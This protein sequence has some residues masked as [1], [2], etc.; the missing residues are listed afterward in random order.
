MSIKVKCPGCTKVLT[1]PDAARGK[2]VKC[3]SCE[4]RVPVPKGEGEAAAKTAK[5]KKPAGP[6]EEEIA[7]ATLDLRKMED[8]KARLCPKCGYDMTYLGDEDEEITECPQ[9]GWDIA[10]GGLGE[11]ARK[12]ALKGPDPDQ[13][14]H[15]LWKNAWKFVFDNYFLA[16]RTFAYTMAASLIMF[17]S[18][19]MYLWISP[20]PP[21]VF[22]GF[23][24]FV[25][26]MVIPGWLWYL[27]TEVIKLTLE[28]KDR[29]KRLNFDFFLASALGV[30]FVVWNIVVAGP[31]LLIP[32]LIGWSLYQFAGL[33][34][35]IPIAILAVCY[36]PVFVLWPVSLTHMTMPIE[37]PGWMFW[38]VVPI[39]FR[40]SKALFT[41][42][43]LFIA[44]NLPIFLIGGGALAFSGPALVEYVEIMEHNAQINRAQA[45]W[46]YYA[47]SKKK[48]KDL[49]DPKELGELGTVEF[50]HELAITIGM[51]AWLICGL[52]G[53]FTSLFSMRTNGY[54]AYYFRDRLD[55]LVLPKERKYVAKLPREAVERKPQSTQEM[56]A[57]AGITMV[58]CVII[59]VLFRVLFAAAG[60]FN[61]EIPM[62]LLNGFDMGLGL[63]IFVGFSIITKAAWEES[64]LWGICTQWFNVAIGVVAVASFISFAFGTRLPLPFLV[65]VGVIGMMGVASI[66]AAFVFVIQFWE[67][68]GVGC[69]TAI[70]SLMGKIVL[71]P[72][73]LLAFSVNLITLPKGF[74]DNKEE[75]QKSGPPVAPG[76]AMPGGAMPPGLGNMPGAPGNMP[77]GPPGL[78]QPREE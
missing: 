9:C 53:A 22:F 27:D 45:L 8:R 39:A 37:Y 18:L 31:L 11:K 70:L 25:A 67:D 64:P 68:A 61:E 13:F 44:T 71:L 35:W 30:K 28:R 36:I 76:E 42:F 72:I 46:D 77:P 5:S 40:C 17:G 73:A 55:L 48:P 47:S 20:W 57:Q 34:L 74:L 62:A 29:F 51:I 59:V 56:F 52:I 2:A 21:R 4:T 14:Y 19:F 75:A 33:P 24:T 12:K 58:I 10:E 16:F 60:V 43:L 26:A 38:K 66:V 32:G 49:V 50:R 15:G 63:A 7:L 6:L 78:M 3:P 54:F 69:L 23:V 41:W 65:L 1:V